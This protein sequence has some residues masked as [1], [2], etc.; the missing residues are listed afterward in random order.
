MEIK[1]PHC[2]IIQR[3]KP[4]KSWKYG[5]MIEKKTEKGTEWGATITCSKYHCKCG[6]NFNFYLS[7][8]GK[9]WTIPKLVKKTS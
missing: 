5:K 3:Q 2:Q 8:K 6:N 9:F 4:K 1:C 7:A